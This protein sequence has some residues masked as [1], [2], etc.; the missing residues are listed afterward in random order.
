MLTKSIPTAA[1]NKLVFTFV[2]QCREC[3]CYGTENITCEM[4][5]DGLQTC[6]ACAPGHQGRQ[7]ESCGDGFFGIPTV[8][9]LYV[10]FL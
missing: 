6:L 1:K 10:F 5:V 4:E 8:S 7:C 2:V 9:I 3:T